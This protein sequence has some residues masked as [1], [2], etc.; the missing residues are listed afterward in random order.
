MRAEEATLLSDV[1]FTGGLVEA[2]GPY[3]LI[4]LIGGNDGE[5]SE[6]LALRYSLHLPEQSHSQEIPEKPQVDSWLGLSLDEEIAALLSLFL[7]IRLRSGGVSRQF[8][9]ESVDPAGLPVAYGRVHPTLSLSQQPVI[10][11]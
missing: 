2:L 8:T 11:G 6:S 4:N 7:S 5:L 10:P 1:T 9:V 3:T